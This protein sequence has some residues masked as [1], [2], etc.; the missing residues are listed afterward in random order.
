MKSLLFLQ[1]HRHL[2]ENNSRPLRGTVL[3]GSRTVETL[4]K[5]EYTM[6]S[7]LKNK[8]V[9]VDIE[10]VRKKSWTCINL[11]PVTGDDFLHFTKIVVTTSHRLTKKKREFF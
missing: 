7:L 3:R 2:L 4:M 11:Y 8:S 9:L 5:M 6:F 10:P 1:G